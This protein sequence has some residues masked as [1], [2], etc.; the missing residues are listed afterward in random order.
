MPDP[1]K[2]LPDLHKVFDRMFS[3]TA[4]K[5]G[6]Q[7]QILFERTDGPGA[8]R[9]SA[10]E[11]RGSSVHAAALQ[12]GRALLSRFSWSGAA[13][14]SSVVGVDLGASAL[15]VVCVNTAK[16][17]PQV[18]A[19]IL[20]EMPPGLD[21]QGRK[22]FYQ[23]HLKALKKQGILNGRVV[24]GVVDDRMAVEMVSMPKMPQ[25][26][27]EKAVIWEAKARMAAE[28]S[29]YCIRHLIIEE[30]MVDGQPHKEVLIFAVP[31]EEIVQP[32]QLIAGYNSRV[33]AAEPGILASVS[34]LEQG[35]FIRQ[36]QFIGVLDIGS[37]HSTLGLIFGGKVRF[38]RS[39]SVTGETITQSIVQYCKVSQAEAEAQKKQRG[40][41]HAKALESHKEGASAH[42]GLQAG[43]AMTLHLEQLATEL[44]HSLR[45][46]TYY[47]LGRGKVNRLDR[48][49]LVGGGALLKNLPA[50][51][52]SRLDTKVEAADPFQ[53]VSVS[54][55]VKPQIGS[56]ELKVRMAAAV[57]LALRPME[58][59]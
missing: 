42:V 21:E 43:H 11:T 50:F 9:P 53:E 54:D 35:R 29:A 52:E 5:Q 2:E 13:G 12:G 18:T 3:R 32:Y 51:L 27:L 19:V 57:G 22:V 36:D 17:F 56:F 41:P 7:K 58:K 40:L 47:S 10:K 8:K 44:D 30:T 16:E 46:V 39:F 38:V 24:M 34:A 1:E 26:D 20:E 25:A 49:F 31:R 55:L 48:L 59:G 28:A 15:K 45:Y 14:F 37:R 4:K 33:T 23:K 6:P